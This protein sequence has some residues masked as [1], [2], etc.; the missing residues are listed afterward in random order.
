MLLSH[1]CIRDIL[2]L[3]EKETSLAS[4]LEWV[5]IRLT[6]FCY[7]LTNYSRQ[8]IAYTLYLLNEAGYID[9]NIIEA[10]GGIVDIFVYRL[11]YSGH[12]FLDTIKADNVWK[13]IKSALTSAGSISLPVI[14]SL[15]SHYALEYLKNL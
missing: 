13:K 8:D 3:C 15:G 4:N 14:H 7:S 1:E 10:N 2:I 5:P 12:E 6:S 9:C 11:T